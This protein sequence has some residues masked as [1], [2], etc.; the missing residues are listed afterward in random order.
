MKLEAIQ[1]MCGH[2][3]DMKKKGVAPECEHPGNRFEPCTI[4]KCPIARAI[5]KEEKRLQE[6][7]E[8]KENV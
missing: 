2:Y 3:F 7:P 6:A 1:K 8:R 5:A 4:K